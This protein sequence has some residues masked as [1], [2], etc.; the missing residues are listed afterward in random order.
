MT[1]KIYFHFGNK[2]KSSIV[3]WEGISSQKAQEDNQLAVTD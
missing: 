3:S 2:L 1:W